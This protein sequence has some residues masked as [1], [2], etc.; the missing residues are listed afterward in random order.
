MGIWELRELLDMIITTF[1]SAVT[2]EFCVSGFCFVG[3]L[4]GMFL[5]VGTHVLVVMI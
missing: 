2:G 1:L 3:K 4:D 5:L